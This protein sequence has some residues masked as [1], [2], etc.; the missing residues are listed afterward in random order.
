[1]LNTV[2][3]AYSRFK[4]APRSIRIAAY[5]STVYATYALILGLVIPAIVQSQAPTILSN[6]LGRHVQVAKISINPFL[7]RIRIDDFDIKESNDQSSFV[8]FKR[9]DLQI[10]FW[11]SILHFTPNIDHLYLQQPNVNLI[12]LDNLG[13]FNFTS[14]IDALMVS[15]ESTKQTKETETS[16]GLPPFYAQDI[17]LT[18][19]QFDFIDQPTG[20]HLQYQGLNIHLPHL[21][22]QAETI[23]KADPS[24]SDQK[25]ATFSDQNH[26]AINVTGADKGSLDLEGKFQLEPFAIEGNIAL[27]NIMLAN[28][29]PF[30]EKQLD[31]KLTNGKF[32][33]S[34]DF[35]AKNE[36]KRFDYSTNNGHFELLDLTFTDGKKE[37]VKLPSLTLNAIALNNKQHAIDIGSLTLNHLWVD[38]L[39]NKQGLD[40]QALFTPKAEAPKPKV[41]L[42]KTS[43]TKAENIDKA[44]EKNENSPS[45]T[46]SPWVVRLHKFAMID[47]DINVKEEAVSH[48]VYWRINPLTIEA[49]NMVSD[50]SKP[51][52]YKIDLDVNSWVKS[53]L[54]H[55]RGHFASQGSIDPKNLIFKGN[56]ELSK[57]DLSQFQTYI[58][59]YLNV[60][61]Q[62]GELSTKGQFSANTKGHA[63]Y[64][65]QANIAK[66]LIRDKLEYQPL[67]QWSNMSVNNLHFD[68]AKKSIKMASIDIK[69]PYTKVLIDKQ[70]RTNIGSLIKPQP[71][72]ASKSSTQSNGKPYSIDIGKISI[73]NGSAFFADYS[74]TP[75]FASGIE[76]LNGAISHLSSTPGTKA[77]V[78][79]KGKINKYAPVTL[80]GDINPL[81]KTPYL[82]LDLIFKSVELTSVNPYSG[83]YAGYYID[84]GQ[85]SLDLKYQLE[86]NHLIGDNHLVIDQLK[87]GEPSDSDLATGLPLKLAIAL[88]Q[89]RNGVIDLGM[90]V[91]GDVND[92]DFSVGD[93]V[94][95]ALTNVITKAATSPFSML[96]GLTGSDGELNHIQYSAGGFSL[97]DEAKGQL[98][99]LATALKERPK[100]TISI[101]GAVNEATDIHALAEANVWQQL[102]LDSGV[103]TMPEDISI[104]TIVT[105][106]DFIDSLEDIYEDQLQKDVGDE[107]DR[108]EQQLTAQNSDGKVSSEALSTALYT[109]LYNQLVDAQTITKDDLGSLAVERARN[110]K[111]YLV[112]EQ[113]L[114]PARIFILDSKSNLVVDSQGAD[115]TID[116]H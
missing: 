79:L 80:A 43:E 90:Q 84:K 97:S 77:N 41:T 10:G 50:L 38:A 61:L 1:M 104:N 107:E 116:V 58:D 112:D 40:L 23:I 25:E 45:H 24:L 91:S 98:T 114:S 99:T 28:F 47:T 106:D 108:I 67:V 74:L 78:D 62:R 34:T 71:K 33:F 18:D 13:N 66:L 5:L 48:G 14:I 7:L 51:I 76:S 56:I 92:P 46:P 44:H 17:Q 94:L 87:L 12:R 59:P 3:V 85:L 32:N 60:R 35:Q 69:T 82:D 53:P 101:T 29:W 19:G 86:N 95:T 64:S 89:D 93:I 27:K 88:L 22:S 110:I 57:L 6:L 113:Q 42:K 96:T 83:T 20:A 37:K 55:P 15:T 65:G 111:A 36:P 105:N 68:Q 81:S 63:N 102:I 115:L 54:D 73:R 8:N 4:Q 70:R 31:A 39:I 26:F 103:D 49:N 2:K 109:S 16:S 72:V 30:A 52:D 21:D 75:S 9:M 100:L 11:R